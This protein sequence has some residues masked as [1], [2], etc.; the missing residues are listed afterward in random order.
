VLIIVL[1]IFVSYKQYAR[2]LRFL[3]LS[4]FTYVLVALVVTED[5]RQVLYSTIIPTIQLN[6]DYVWNLVAVLGTTIS[7][8]LFFWQAA[9]EVEEDIDSGKITPARKSPERN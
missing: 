6:K 3:T 8:Y 1:Q 2:L 5:W 7:P 4:L 9:Q